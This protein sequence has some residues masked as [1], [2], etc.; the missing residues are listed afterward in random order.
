MAPE[1]TKIAYSVVAKLVRWVDPET[2]E[3]DVPASTSQVQTEILGQQERKVV[4]LPSQPETAPLHIT[5]R[6]E[7]GFFNSSYVTSKSKTVKKGVFSGALGRIT[8][9][10]AQPAAV[11]IDPAAYA[12]G[13]YHAQPGT[14]GITTAHLNVRFDPAAGSNGAMPRIGSIVYR[15]KST[16][17]HGV[18]G[19]K[20]LPDEQVRIAPHEAST[21]A[22]STTVMGVPLKEC[23][24]V[25][26]GWVRQEERERPPVYER[27][28]SG[29]ST[30]SL[31]SAGTSPLPSP[32][33]NA[34][35][36]VPSAASYL[37]VPGQTITPSLSTKQ[38]KQNGPA[39]DYTTTL[40]VPI[41]LPP[42]KLWL[43][44]FH[45]CLVSR[46]YVLSLEVQIHPPAKG[47]PSFCVGLRVPLQICVKPLPGLGLGMDM[48][49]E[50]DV[51]MGGD[52]GLPTFASLH[53]RPNPLVRVQ[54]GTSSFSSGGGASEH[55]DRSLR[56]RR[57]DGSLSLSS[58][59]ASPSEEEMGER[60]RIA[61][62]ASEVDAQLALEGCAA[63]AAATAP[64]S[65]SPPPDYVA[66]FSGRSPP[67]REGRRV[68]VR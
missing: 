33:L 58:G 61:S 31:S 36:T 25:R 66:S 16:T 29:Y 65:L 1:M 34:D 24:L 62:I 41:T 42:N 8:V 4:I 60:E 39:T 38:S 68:V 27:R 55:T 32:G 21:S 22:Y 30:A 45:S 54:S 44:T 43:P 15:I 28:D 67:P 13:T 48:G 5:E 17:F 37:H 3:H 47:V 19:V 52:D 6:D 10:A 50:M 53:L 23:A 14:S 20:E 64:L 11:L 56:T 9:S 35:G 49:M 59:P 46:W 7:E 57:S 40:R 26:E 18:R 12:A 2:D 51:G 63:A